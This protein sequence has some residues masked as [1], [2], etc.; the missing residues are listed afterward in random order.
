[1]A[2]VELGEEESWETKVKFREPGEVS[3]QVEASDTQ[4]AK[5][6]RS[7]PADGW[8]YSTTVTIKSA[9]FSIH[10]FKIVFKGKARRPHFSNSI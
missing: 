8:G 9:V 7:W 5:L 10:S 4:K 1:M 6:S 2:V 3:S